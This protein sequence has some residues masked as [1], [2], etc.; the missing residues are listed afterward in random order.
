MRK[1]IEY[2]LEY[3]RHWSLGLDLRIMFRTVALVLR[4]ARAF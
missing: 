3:L 2:D 4:D 1:R